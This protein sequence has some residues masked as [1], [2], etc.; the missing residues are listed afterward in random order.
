MKVRYI[1]PN[2]GVDSLTDNKVYTVVSVDAPWIQI[3]DD[4]EEGYA[5]LINEPR[6][7]DSKVAGKFEI[8]E[9]DDKGTLKKA[10][11]ELR[12]WTTSS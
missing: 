4:S 5:Y 8:V 12:K 2:Q 1:G 10:F 9:D 3:I 11:E 6:L 7:L